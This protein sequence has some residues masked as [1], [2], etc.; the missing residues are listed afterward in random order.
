MVMICHTERSER[1]NPHT[2]R[3][4]PS[5]RVVAADSALTAAGTTTAGPRL[6]PIVSARPAPAALERQKGPNRETHSPQPTPRHRPHAGRCRPVAEAAHTQATTADDFDEDERRT[7]SMS[8]LQ[9]ERLYRLNQYIAVLAVEN[10][11]A[12]AALEDMARRYRERLGWRRR[13]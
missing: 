5:Q 11:T 8:E 12:I 6:N 7:D 13:S 2:K 10:P 1:R 9:R 3:N 4:G